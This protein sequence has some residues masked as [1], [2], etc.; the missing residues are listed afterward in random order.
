MEFNYY[1]ELE[2]EEKEMLE[3][4]EYAEED[5]EMDDF[6][7][8]MVNNKEESNLYLPTEEDQKFNISTSKQLHNLLEF[9]KIVSTK[10]RKLNSNEKIYKLEEVD[11]IFSKK[12]QNK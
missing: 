8:E 3:A 6:I 12:N 2:E 11:R 5:I 1:K 10:Q 4:M 7:S 9:K